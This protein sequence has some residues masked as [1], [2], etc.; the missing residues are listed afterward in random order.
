MLRVMLADD[1]QYERDY[2]EKTIKEYYPTLLKVVYKA[3]DGVEFM[4]KLDEYKPHMILLDIKMPRMDGFETAKLIRAKYPDIHVVIVSAYSDFNYAKQ[5]M[6]LGITEYLLKPYADSELCATLDRVI[7]RLREKEDTLAMLS[8]LEE[9]KEANHFDFFK[10]LE[11]DIMWNVFLKRKKAEDLRKY[12]ELWGVGEGWMKV[13]LISSSALSSMGDFSQEVLKNYFHMDGV[14]VMNSIWMSQMAIGLFAKEKDSFIELN[15]CIHRARNY[16]VEEHQIPV[17]CG[18][19]G[20]YH[21]LDHLAEA[22]EEAA[23]FITDFSEPEMEVQFKDI[24]GR[25][26]KICELEEKMVESYVEEKKEETMDSLNELVE[27][28]EQGLDYQ[29]MAIKLNFGRSLFTIMQGI[30]RIPGVRIKTTEA[31]SQM[32]RLEQ[33]NFSGDHLKYH[34]D[35]FADMKVLK[36]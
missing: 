13:V 1:E 34:L 17:A 11:K 6:K 18:V 31:L 32:E 7:A 3:K 5:A 21:G 29:D 8:N 14:I 15:S 23:S 12:F 16:L 26:E 9:E 20:A 19:S 22:Y 27:I 30:N 2:L 25:M 24:K 35:F 33:L 28:L 36:E 10:D 4:E